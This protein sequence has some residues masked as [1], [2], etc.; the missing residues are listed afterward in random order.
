MGW[1]KQQTKQKNENKYESDHY[2]NRTK[3]TI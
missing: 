1:I 3:R 2:I